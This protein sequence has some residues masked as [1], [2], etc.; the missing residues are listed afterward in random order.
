MI[1]GRFTQYTKVQYERMAAAG[2][3]LIGNLIRRGSKTR[4]AQ[5]EKT[6][7]KRGRRR[8]PGRRKGGE[9]SAPDRGA[10]A[11]RMKP[12]RVEP[13]DP[14]AAERDRIVG[15]LTCPEA[16]GRER[17]ARKLALAPN[18][19]LEKAREILAVR[20]KRNVWLEQMNAEADT[21]LSPDITEDGD[22]P[23]AMAQGLISLARDAGM[24]R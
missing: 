14:A 13:E 21:P 18:I 7:A 2:G 22:D 4:E 19:T 1:R 17:M 15:I 10:S 24:I 6:L 12:E 16:S 8:Q 11:V 23:R 20:P 3:R 9:L 5:A